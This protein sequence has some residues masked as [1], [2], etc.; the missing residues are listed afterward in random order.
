LVLFLDLDP[1]KIVNDSLGHP[2]GDVLLEEIAL[3]LKDCVRPQDGRPVFGSQRRVN[4][5]IRSSPVTY[6]HWRIDRRQQHRNATAA[7]PV[8]KLEWATPWFAEPAWAQSRKAET[9]ATPV[10]RRRRWPRLYTGTARKPD[11]G[12]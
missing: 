4:V 8:P 11:W 7:L 3:R 6:E 2:A 5:Q 12:P 1:F 10:R 9:D